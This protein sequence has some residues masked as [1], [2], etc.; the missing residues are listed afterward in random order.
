MSADISAGLP[1]IRVG[2]GAVVLADDGSDA[3][4]VLLVQRGRPPRAGEW[5]LPGGHL[6]SGERPEAAACR[7]I[8]EET[9]LAARVLL[10][11]DVVTLLDHDADGRLGRHYV[12]I[13]YLALAPRAEPVAA[14][15]AAAAQW[16]AQDEA[17]SRV[18]WDE[19]RRI[20]ARAFA[21][22]RSWQAS[23]VEAAH[24]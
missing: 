1:P 23:G 19:T 20:L 24:A 9:G 17:V 3:P 6:E 13:D 18:T 14:D 21:M 2:V 4:D 8:R 22:H 15:D 12:L 11:I 16:F 7:E 10:L 5:S